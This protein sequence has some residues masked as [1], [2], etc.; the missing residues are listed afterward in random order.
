MKRGLKENLL[1]MKKSFKI[2]LALLILL[3]LLF[4]FVAPTLLE[5]VANKVISQETQKLSA[6]AAE[7]HDQL[8]IA[9]LHADALLWNRDL[10]ERNDHGHVDVPRLIEGNV[11]LQ[12]FTVVSKIPN[13]LNFESN[14]ADNFDLITLLG[15]AQRWPSETWRSLRARALFQ[16]N[17]LKK[18]EKNSGGK[19]KIIR[20][21]QDLIKYNLMRRSNPGMTAGFLGLEGSQVL[22][23]ELGNVQVLFDAGFRMMAPTHFFDTEVGGSAHGEKKGGLTEFGKKVIQYM[24]R[25]GMIVDV[26]H[27]SPKTI[28]DILDMSTKPIFVSHTGV[29]G[30]CDNVRNLSDEHLKGVAATGGVIGIAFFEQATCGED[31]D[32]IVRAIQYTANLVGVEHVALGSDWDGAVATPFDAAHISHLTQA[33]LD[34]GFAGSEIALIMGGNVQRLLLEIL[35]H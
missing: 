6:K 5:R 32:S 24:Q 26:A 35:P 31:V 18:V 28:D 23:G 2:L 30:T 4:F 15:I 17:K 20:T 25:I 34:A 10:L 22:E 9:D 16:A 11:A 12:A 7:L 19:F 29:R 21:Q 3:T 27:A 13:G 33:L 14:P 8:W 1:Q